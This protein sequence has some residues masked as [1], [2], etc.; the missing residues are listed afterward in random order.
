MAPDNANNE[1]HWTKRDATISFKN[2]KRNVLFY[3]DVD[4]AAKLIPD[5]QT[6]TV[7]AGDQVV[8]TFTVD[9]KPD[10]RRIPISAAQLGP[11][12]KVELKIS[13]DKT[14]VPAV[15]TAGGKGDQRELGV[16]V[17]HAFV[18]PQ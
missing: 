18:E 16:R 11:D 4:A 13:V 17:F 6:V 12:D 2:P 14:F 5:P 1:W 7:R 9:K 8:D 3:L 15:V 10:V